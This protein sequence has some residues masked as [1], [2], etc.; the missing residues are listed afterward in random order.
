MSRF[1]DAFNIATAAIEQERHTRK[2]RASTHLAGAALEA[3]AKA[4]LAVADAEDLWDA[5]QYIQDWRDSDTC[6]DTPEHRQRLTDLAQRLREASNA[7][8]RLT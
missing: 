2:N 4:G 5:N 8:A 7:A 6:D 3:L 1:I